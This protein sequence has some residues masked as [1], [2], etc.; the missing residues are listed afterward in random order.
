MHIYHYAPYEPSA[1]K[2]LMGRYATREA[3]VDRMLRA[4]LFVDLYAVVRRAL[5]A[6]VERYSIKDLEQFYG[7]SRAVELADANINL[8]VVERALEA[9][10]V[11]AI[12]PDVRSAVEGYNLDDC[13]SALRLRNWL[14][15]LRASLEASGTEVPR[16][17]RTDGTASEPI[18]E[19]SAARAGAFR[20]P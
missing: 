8:R 7:F 4:G 5:R 6:S 12:T 16:P 20:L 13:R 1:F 2:R 14:E 9:S 3:E 11:D 15:Q 19:S 18:T 10:A 17:E